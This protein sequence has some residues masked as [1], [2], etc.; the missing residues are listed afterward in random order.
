MLGL[1]DLFYVANAYVDAILVLEIDLFTKI[2]IVGVQT[3]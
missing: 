3:C 1:T 2:S